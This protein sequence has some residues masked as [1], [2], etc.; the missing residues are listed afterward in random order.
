MARKSMSCKL[1][2]S[3]QLAAC[4]AAD[5]FVQEPRPSDD[6]ASE[7]R[8]IRES[9]ARL[10]ADKVEAAMKLQP[11]S[12]QTN[13]LLAAMNSRKAVVHNVHFNASPDILKA[14]FSG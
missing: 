9:L 11:S 7:L 6:L 3:I 8:Q 13:S 5:C 12:V 1:H 4:P 2:R 14:H 10:Q